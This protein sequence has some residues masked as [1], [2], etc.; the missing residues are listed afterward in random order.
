MPNIGENIND[1]HDERNEVIFMSLIRQLWLLVI[2]VTATTCTGSLVTSLWSNRHYLEDQLQIKNHDNA[3]SLAI[4]LSQQSGDIESIRLLISAQYDTGHYRRIRLQGPDGKVIIDLS[5]KPPPATTPEWFVLLLP[6]ES[7]PGVAQVSSGWQQIGSLEVISHSAFAHG[8]LWEGAVNLTVLLTLVGLISGLFGTI[9]VRRTMSPLSGLVAQATALSERRF[10]KS[11]LSSVTELITLTQ[12]MNSMVDRVQEQYAEH[13]TTVERLRHAATSDPVTGLSN[14]EALQNEL[15]N[16]LNNAALSSHGALLMI[17]VRDL[18]RINQEL[19][20]AQTD[21][22][23]K[24]MAGKLRSFCTGSSDAACGRLNGSDFALVLPGR[25]IGSNDLASLSAELHSLQAANGT[26]LPLAIGSAPLA[27]GIGAGR[28]L[29]NADAALA[30]AEADPRGFAMH[31]EDSAT[32][33]MSGQQDWRKDFQ[34]TLA[35]RQII[36]RVLPVSGADGTIRHQQVEIHISWGVDDHYFPPPD[37]LPFAIRTGMA[38]AIEEIAI[39]QCVQI[40]ET[41]ALPIAL[42][43]SEPTLRDASVLAHLVG[44][45]SSSQPAA[46]RLCIEIPESLV[47]KDPEFG[48]DLGRTLRRTGARVGLADA[49]TY[50]SRIPSIPSLQLE[51]IKVAANLSASQSPAEQ[52]Y[53]A[54]VVSMAHGMGIKAYL[55]SAAGAEANA[56]M[57][58]AGADGVVSAGSDQ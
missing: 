42:R 56:A 25:E 34:E 18:Q 43:L 44:L 57:M 4:S 26:A 5:N 39:E 38:A 6:I 10:I 50:F 45:L 47:F 32:T 15:R 40:A 8:V 33:D 51:H 23:L 49:G 22:L 35:R 55:S 30:E 54:G 53:L 36:S 16:I 48:Y 19:G 20:H 27:P 13:A 28:L 37:W 17:R 2:I 11:E 52:A 3:A 21:R 41:S 14:R 31:E 29:A 7:I 12:A 58:M 24:E 9:A 46:S 1:K